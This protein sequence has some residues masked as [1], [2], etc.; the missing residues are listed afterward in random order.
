MS[1]TGIYGYKPV[2]ADHLRS[3][4]IS[5]ATPTPNS[6]YQL[7][8]SIWTPQTVIPGLTFKTS[9]VFAD[10]TDITKQLIFS[11]SGDTTG[12]NTTFIFAQTANRTWTFQNATDVVV[13][14]AT[15]DILTGKTITGDTITTDS[16]FA[17]TSDQ[18]KKLFFNLAG[19]NSGKKTTI[20][21]GTSVDQT[22]TIPNGTDTFLTTQSTA[23]VT[24]KDFLTT[25]TRF[26]DGSDQT[27][28]IVLD[29]SG[30]STSKTCTIK[31]LNTDNVTYS[32]TA[33]A[34]SDTIPLLGTN[35]TFTGNNTFN[36]VQFSNV[37]T[38]YV[39]ATLNY[40]ELQDGASIYTLTWSTTPVTSATCKVKVHRFSNHVWLNFDSF[41]GTATSGVTFTASSGNVL[42]A[43]WRLPAGTNASSPSP[44]LFSKVIQITN[45]GTT[46][47]GKLQMDS[48][49]VIAIYSTVAGAAFTGSGVCGWDN[50]CVDYSMV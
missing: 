20:V 13:G 36:W 39:P 43:R 32:I 10:A 6:I 14:R 34:A 38:S 42:P 35:N 24:N 1:D 2:N 15:T 49:G 19:T 26:L 33:T 4:Q 31:P 8:N 48:T 21:A 11:L 44:N 18:T 27:R 30:V 22:L 23:V 37:T 50:F 3:T 25:S 5:T 28:K 16:F 40:W 7:A 12:T 17:D 41:S 45:A 29:A 47:A 9:C 46:Q